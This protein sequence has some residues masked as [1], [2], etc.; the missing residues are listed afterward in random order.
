MT[1]IQI[2]ENTRFT[3]DAIADSKKKSALWN[4]LQ[5]I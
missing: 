4:K 2:K 5:D 3:D 1:E